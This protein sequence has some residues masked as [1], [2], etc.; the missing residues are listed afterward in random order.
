VL[1]VEGARVELGGT[2]E[3]FAPF[4]ETADQSPSGMSDQGFGL[5]LRIRI[6]GVDAPEC[7]EVR[8]TFATAGVEP[9]ELVENV[10]LHCG[11]TLGMYPQLPFVL[12]SDYSPLELDVVARVT[13][14]G[15]D[16]VHLRVVIPPDDPQG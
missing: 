13:G 5:F 4:D 2:G 6:T 10:R 9:V 16:S 7:V 11:E 3:E 15:S 14:I 8:L 1:P 12:L